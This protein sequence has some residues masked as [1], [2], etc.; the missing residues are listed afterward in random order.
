M[1]R[2]LIVFDMDTNCLKNNYHNP[3][4]Q[5][6]Y[7]EI[8]SVFKK[9]GFSNIQGSVYLGDEG[10]SEAH[11]TI[12]IQELTARFDWFYPCI[13]NIRFYRIESDLD[14]QFIADNV[15][16]AKQAFNQRLALLKQSLE[17]AGLSPEQINRILDE[18]KFELEPV[19]LNLEHKQ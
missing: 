12:A 16:N 9:H 13:S 4:W 15:Y 18:Q 7:F 3:S 19:S 6:A 14:A 17:N 1:S 8:K 2:H 11:G 10:I 5:N